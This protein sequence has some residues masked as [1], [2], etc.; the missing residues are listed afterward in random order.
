MFTLI[1]KISL[2]SILFENIAVS[3]ITTH[4]RLVLFDEVCASFNRS[5]NRHLRHQYKNFVV[6]L[7][8]VELSLSLVLG[9]T[10]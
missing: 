3:R 9:T 2:R 1:F 6:S 10:P 8:Q 7:E 5:H 4:I